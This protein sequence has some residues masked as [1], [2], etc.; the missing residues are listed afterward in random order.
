MGM[1]SGR[2]AAKEAK[3]NQAVALSN[4]GQAYTPIN[5]T[6]PGGQG[7]SFNQGMPAGGAVGGNPP[8]GELVYDGSRGQF[9]SDGQG[10]QQTAS[11]LQ[12]VEGTRGRV[13][14]TNISDA[15]VSAGDLAPLR[16]ENVNAVTGMPMTM[17]M[18]T[19]MLLANLQQAGGQFGEASLGDLSQ[20]QDFSRLGANI[21]ATGLA[22][23]SDFAGD[24]RNQAQSAFGGLAGTQQEA[25]QRT[26]DLLR[27]QAQPGIDRSMAAQQQNLFATGRMGTT[28]GALQTEAFA[29]GLANADLDRQ[30]MASQEGRAA[31]TAQLGLGTGL[32]AQQDATMT[33]AMNR[34]S[35]ML[36]LNTD[37]GQSRYNRT[38]D[39]ANTNFT[40]A[41][42]LLEASPQALEQAIMSGA[43]GLQGQGI[44]NI[45]NIDNNALN[46]ANFAQQL[47][48]NQSAARTGQQQVLNAQAA[49][50]PDMTNANMFSQ[51]SGALGGMTGGQGVLGA[52]GGLFGGGGG[53]APSPT[54]NV[55]SND[56]L[57]YLD[58]LGGG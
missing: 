58:S 54:G 42:Q 37:L 56:V 53:S 39:L 33:N 17:D 4:A 49:A 50:G 9:Y 32:A 34:F 29:K 35:S 2:R 13:K 3:K 24:L 43:L 36:G 10:G 12:V 47:M 8:A 19:Q 55:A 41:G 6:G 7:V 48:S 52:L 46:M 27:Q 15:N 16:G 1:I 51:L 40:R 25:Q 45:S 20:M 21:G 18:S 28:G 26:L 14:R 22:D 31:Q 23:A 11:G 38:S 44:T 30:L 5:V 57:S